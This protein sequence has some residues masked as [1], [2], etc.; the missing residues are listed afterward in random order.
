[1]TLRLRRV[2]WIARHGVPIRT[3]DPDDHD[4]DDLKP[5]GSWI[6]DARIVALGEGSHHSGSDFLA[7][8]R[9]VAFLHQQMGFEVLAW[10]SG[11]YG[12]RRVDEALCQGRTVQEAA[13]LGIFDVWA[14]TR[15]A[16]AVLEYARRSHATSRP[17]SI[18]GFDYQ[19]SSTASREGFTTDIRRYVESVLD[20][21]RARRALE[22]LSQAADAEVQ[23]LRKGYAPARARDEIAAGCSTAMEKWGKL[24]QWWH[25]EGPA[26]VATAADWRAF[27]D[28][29][30]HVQTLVSEAAMGRRFPPDEQSEFW[31]MALTN[32]RLLGRVAL[33]RFRWHAPDSHAPDIYPPR[34]IQTRNWNRREHRNARLVEFLAERYHRGKKIVLWSHNLH[35]VNAHISSDW[36]RLQSEPEAAGGALMGT[37]LAERYGVEIFSVGFVAHGGVRGLIPKPLRPAGLPPEAFESLCHDLGH[38]QMLVPFRG[39]REKAHPMRGPLEMSVRGY[40]SE[41]LPDWTQAFDAI[42]YI[43][44]MRPPT[45][46]DSGT[47]SAHQEEPA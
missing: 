3:L 39:I 22:L 12:C 40:L 38:A 9:L 45:L 29:V 36:S 13:A 33:D 4:F 37:V 17:L 28:P 8:S 35:A 16:R 46:A 31:I 34:R 10:E 18:A 19:F 41:S 26:L 20:G 43:D 30:A 27:D 7:K 24:S 15:E 23:L 5:F 44:E 2:E 11:M 14:K 6:G 25:S 21:Q 47:V 1:M 42:F 32:W